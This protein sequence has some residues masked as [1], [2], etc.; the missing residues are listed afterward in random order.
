MRHHTTCIR[1][2]TE[3]RHITYDCNAFVLRRIA[4]VMHSRFAIWCNCTMHGSKARAPL[5]TS[6]VYL[7]LL[8]AC[9]ISTRAS[10]VRYIHTHLHAYMHTYTHTHIH[11]CI[12]AYRHARMH[13]SIHTCMHTHRHMHACMHAC[14][15]SCMHACMHAC[16]HGFINT[17]TRIH[18]IHTH[19]CVHACMH[20]CMHARMRACMLTLHTL[21]PIHTLQVVQ[22]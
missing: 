10:L 19:T 11:T 14:M 15:H 20:S 1:H 13:A 18:N 3:L 9:H 5:Y 4:P 16:M 6:A 21:L 17:Y 12:H 2:A 7:D 8:A 22:I